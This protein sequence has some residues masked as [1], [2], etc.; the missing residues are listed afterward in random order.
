MTKIHLE[1]KCKA[2]SDYI[3]SHQCDWSLVPDP[4][5]EQWGI[6]LQDDP[7]HNR[8]L[9]PVFERGKTCG[10]IV[11]EGE[12]VCRWGDT[13]RAD[14]TF[15]V[16]KT[17]LAVVA[18]VGYDQGLLPDI[19]Q[20][21]SQR[22]PGIGFDDEH[23]RQVT[24]RQMLQFTSE[25]QGTCFGI[26]DQVEHFRSLA[27]QPGG[28]ARRK[29]DLRKLGSPGSYWEYN[30]VRINQFSLA[31]L[32][33]FGRPLP[34]V[35]YEHIMQPLGASN[36]WRWPGYENSWVNIDGRNIQSV[37]GGGHWG[38][39]MVISADDQALIAQL[40]INFGTPDNTSGRIKLLSR[41]WIEMMTHACP[42]APYYGFF[43]WLNH[44]HIISHKA[45]TSSFFAMGIGGQVVLHD[46]ENKLVG[47]YRWI[48]N[49]HLGA[50]VDMTYDLLSI[51]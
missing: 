3:E 38:G 21:I 23:N 48:D 28:T 27:S 22:L 17:C 35:L 8:L 43:T 50:I 36:S 31:L 44:E 14:M 42:I 2:L 18:G 45:P 15:S 20:P 46:P 11:V 37:P 5:G 51:G 6:H 12:T 32:H 49:D 16:T 40:L 1:N 41:E 39:G 33:L 25:W 47:V 30:D 10:V 24:W 9:G 13:T 34:E 19:D 26:P 7:P 4:S 29:G